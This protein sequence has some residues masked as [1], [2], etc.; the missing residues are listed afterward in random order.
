MYPGKNDDMPCSNTLAEIQRDEPYFPTQGPD[1]DT[2]YDDEQA[3]LTAQDHSAISKI[4]QDHIFSA[5]DLVDALVEHS[6]KVR[7]GLD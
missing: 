3:R 4:I 1:P 5:K 6:R 2:R 7:R